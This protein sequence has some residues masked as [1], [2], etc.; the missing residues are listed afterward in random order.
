MTAGIVDLASVLYL[1]VLPSG[2]VAWHR[3]V[4][5]GESW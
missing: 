2:V 5:T 4:G 1:G 3:T